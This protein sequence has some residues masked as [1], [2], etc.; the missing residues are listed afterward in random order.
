MNIYIVKQIEG[1]AFCESIEGV[2]FSKERADKQSAECNARP[3]CT[4][5][6]VAHEVMDPWEATSARECA[7]RKD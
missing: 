7:S 4:S 5:R 1:S 3:S 2:W 6:V